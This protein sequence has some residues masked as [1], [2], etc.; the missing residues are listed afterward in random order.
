MVELKG[1][2]DLVS[3]TSRQKVAKFILGAANRM[4]TRA[5]DAF[6]GYGVMIVGITKNG[7]EGVPQSK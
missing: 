5:A 1:P 2:T 3:K 7:V 4:P 6:E